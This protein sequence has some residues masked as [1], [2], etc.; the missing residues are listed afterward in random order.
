MLTAAVAFIMQPWRFLNGAGKFLSVIG[1]YAVFLGPMTGV[2]FADYYII[3]RRKLKLT[4][5]Y[6][7]SESSVYWYTKG[8]NWRAPVSWISGVW[9]VLPGFVQR[10]QDPTVE[11][12]GWSQMYYLAV[13]SPLLF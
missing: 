3:R 10:V 9:L 4:S 8:I 5:L 13:S 1:G 6:D 7:L 2:M 12:A 11:L